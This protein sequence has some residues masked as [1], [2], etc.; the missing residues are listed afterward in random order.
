MGRLKVF[1]IGP[2]SSGILASVDRPHAFDAQTR[3]QAAPVA[4]P[5]P[6]A[7]ASNPVAMVQQLQRTAGNA[8][9][10]RMLQQRALMRDDTA[11]CSP[12]EQAKLDE[13]M[14]KTYTKE[15]FHPSTG[16]GLFD[17][18]YAPGDGLLTITLGI[19]FSFL[20]G[21]PAD[22]T[23]VASVG[24]PAKAATYKPEQFNWT[25]EESDA[26]KANAVSTI[27]GIWGN[28]YTFFT[29]KACW[30]D[31]LPPVNV[32]IEVVDRPATGEGKAH[33]VT[34][35]TKWPTEPGLEESV[36]PPGATADQSTARFH[37]GAENG[38]TTPDVDQYSTT[39]GSRGRYGQVDTDNPGTINFAQG[40]SA[41]SA[42]DKTKLQN[43]GKTLGAP[44]MPPFPVT[45]TGHSSS[46]GRPERN[47]TLSEERARNVSNEIVTGG[48][49]RQPATVGVGAT[50]AG[51][52]PE[53]RRVDIT[54]GAFN[55]SQTTIAHEAGHMLGLG[56]EYAS[57]DTG[58]RPAGTPVAHSALAQR[59]IPGQQPILAKHSENIMS[60]GTD[61]KPHHYVTFLEVLGV[62]TG[63]AGQ[64]DIK[65]AAPVG[66]FPAPT[67]DGT[68]VA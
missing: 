23:W 19:S 9:V 26:W 25:T 46:E 55:S 52:T 20:N 29:Q 34:S 12:E 10:A 7:L 43:F 39:T 53:W 42:D 24:G 40:S 66:D 16:R 14:S 8:A 13:L 21:N 2:R 27:Q 36:T 1:P 61:V 57:A 59:L 58:S 11:T 49:Q 63:T 17:A 48:A 50:G 51:P 54:V 67:P 18:I 3:D 60:T 22:P 47:Q 41:P 64:W 31:K 38:I 15:D 30:A 56:D 44:D 68:A 32:K 28:Q 62:M 33:F 5:V 45:V 35:V 4:A 6:E 65:P 37:E